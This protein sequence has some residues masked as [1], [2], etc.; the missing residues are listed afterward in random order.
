MKK[1]TIIVAFMAIVCCALIN[2]S[3]DPP[4]WAPAKGW[5]KKQE[6]K[7][8]QQ[9]RQN[10]KQ[11]AIRNRLLDTDVVVSIQDKKGKTYVYNLTKGGGEIKDSIAGLGRILR[12]KIGNCEKNVQLNLNQ[13]RLEGE[14][15]CPNVETTIGFSIV[16]MKRGGLAINLFDADSKMKISEED[17]GDDEEDEDM[18]E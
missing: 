13:R 17:E 18:M 14:L 9:G 2:V 3:A 16:R 4:D 12:L 7:G 6:G 1:N 15:N 10:L 11:L 8:P 5:R